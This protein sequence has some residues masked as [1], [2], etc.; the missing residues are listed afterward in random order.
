MFPLQSPP[1][2]FI[3]SPLTLS[4]FPTESSRRSIGRVLHGQNL[5]KRSERG[6]TEGW[7]ELEE[8]VLE[9]EL[10]ELLLRSRGLVMDREGSWL[11]VEVV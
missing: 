3:L 8:E 11:L 7:P 5:P 2:R 4:F 6:L 9:L 1:L 10:D